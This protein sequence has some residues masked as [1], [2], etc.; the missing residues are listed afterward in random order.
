M[1]TLRKKFHNK[2]LMRKYMLE[3]IRPIYLSRANM[4]AMLESAKNPK[5]PCEALLKA[6][7]RWLE[8]TKGKTGG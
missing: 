4:L 7:Q 5:P 2:K 6:K 8:L 1:K 3:E